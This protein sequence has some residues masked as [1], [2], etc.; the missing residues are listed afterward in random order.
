MIPKNITKEH[1]LAA[2]EKIDNHEIPEVRKS[3]KFLLVHE[4]REYPPKYVISIAHE[5]A[6]RQ[7]LLPSEFSG[8]KESNDF[9]RNLGFKIINRE[10]SGKTT[11]PDKPSDTT[12]SKSKQLIPPAPKPQPDQAPQPKPLPEEIRDGNTNI[13]IAT[14]CVETLGE[15]DNRARLLLL[16]QTLSQFSNDVD[17]LIFPAG[18]FNFQTKYEKNSEKIENDILN[19]IRKSGSQAILCVGIDAFD[20]EDQLA[21]ALN[22][23][24]MLA[25][26][27]KFF[28]TREESPY[29]RLAGSPYIG[30]RNH[31]RTFMIRDK[32][33]YLAI[34]YDSFGIRHQ[35]VQ[36]I[37]ADLIV[38]LV[39]GFYP[40]GE[41]GSGDV[42]FAKH[43]FAG[44]S[45]QWGCPTYAAA[46]FFNRS[47][48]PNWPTGVLWNQGSKNT[49]DWKYSYNAIT[50]PP[51]TSVKHSG[52]KNKAVITIF[53]L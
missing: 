46:V 23:D 17:L 7:E 25:M 28:P 8:G 49:K 2:I 40:P 35:K 1:I 27:R 4:D 37:G 29:I 14:V 44:A 53:D 34:C 51:R 9:L 18:Y 26:A 33:A 30:E 32:K 5:L 24:G 21:L 16:N 42:Y 31:E 20:S 48:P 50:Q 10:Q 36:G 43:G 52:A 22:K 11:E 3:T 15:P 39:H 47:V 41:G 6:N 45:K 19:A 38:N 13:R 12:D